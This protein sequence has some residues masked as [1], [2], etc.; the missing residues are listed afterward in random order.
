VIRGGMSLRLEPRFALTF[1]DP[2]DSPLILDVAIDTAFAGFIALP[3]DIIT[4]LALPFLNNF[5]VVL[6]NGTVV[7]QPNYEARIEWQGRVR[8][9]RVIEMETE[10]LV[11]INFLWGQRITI[12]VVA[13][14][15][16]T[17]EPI[18]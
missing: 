8:T 18:P 15:P 4:H 9:V 14:G 13:G 5:P 1:L 11:G 12:D 2:A 7:I 3:P 16:V 6:A 10:P 17:I